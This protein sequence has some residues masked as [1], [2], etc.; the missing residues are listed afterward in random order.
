MQM[1]KGLPII[2]NKIPIEEQQSIPHHLLGNI[3][4][5]EETWVV[6]VYKKE[7]NRI[8]QEI[9]SRGRL[10]IV[11]GGTH[12]Y[13]NAL[14]FK[15]TILESDDE[16]A[17]Q[18]PPA[19]E[20]SST[21]FPILDDTT[22]VMWNRLKEVDPVM[23]DRWHPKDRRKIRRSLEIFLTT[24][25]RASDIY[26]EQKTRKTRQAKPDD[27][28]A[29]DADHDSLILW[30]HTDDQVLKDRL[31][32][33]VDKMLDC[34]LMDE[35]MEMD[36]YVKSARTAGESIDFMQGIWQSIG[37]KEFQPYLEALHTGV[38]GSELAKLK[39]EC[40][41]KM[42]TATR[43]YAKYQVKWIHK[44]MLPLLEEQ[45][46][47][48]RLYVL[49]STDVARYNEQVTA[50]GISMTEKFLKN[51][52]MP[53]PPSISEAA[54]NVLQAAKAASSQAMPCR[55]F[56]EICRTT[57]V[58]EE[59]WIKHLRGKSHRRN[60]RHAKRTALV[61][62]ESVDSSTIPQAEPQSPA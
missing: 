8:I 9:R 6:G 20:D 28:A 16:S 60:I 32:K 58:T 42:K 22:E 33:R 4:L 3:G 19:E 41:E 29:Q 40:L 43:R 38:D 10:P 37:F 59:G 44:K 48:D 46:K 18:P 62:M 57:T 61:P 51:E 2:T 17:E 7:A 35:I 14:L 52:D 49:D 56:C 25:R 26:E 34:G 31:D 50:Q 23:A 54:Q 15:D 24:G 21:K 5:D 36:A 30:V 12:Y 11:V 27:N 47:M 39:I 53:A 1:Y 55:N 45:G 13:T